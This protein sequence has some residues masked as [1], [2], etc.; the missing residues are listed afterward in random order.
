[1]PRNRTFARGFGGAVLAGLLAGVL[2]W[3]FGGGSRRLPAGAREGC[4]S[5]HVNVRGLAAA[6]APERVSCVACHLGDP[7]APEAAAAHRDMIRVPGHLATAPR[8]CGT[9]DCHPLLTAQIQTALMATGRGIVAVDRF[10]FGEAATPDGAGHLGRLGHSAADEHLRQLCEPCHLGFPKETPA[11]VHELSRGGGCVACHLRYSPAAGADLERMRTDRTAPATHPSLTLQVTDDHCFGCHSRSGRISLNYAGWSELRNGTNAP[12]PQTRRLADGRAV[13]AQPDDVHHAAG[14]ACIDCHTWRETMGDGQAHRH[15]EEQV[16]IGCADCH[17][18]T[19]ATVDA[20]ALA[21]VDRKLLALRGWPTN[22]HFLRIRKTG[23]ALLNARVTATGQAVLRSK[24]GDREWPLRPPAPACGRAI[25][26]HDRLSCKSCHAAWAPQCI[27]CHTQ[28]EARPDFPP[29]TLWA[30]RYAWMEYPGRFLAEPPVL[31]VRD[32]GNRIEPF[33]PGMILTLNTNAARPHAQGASGDRFLRLHA[34]V[35]PHT[36]AARGRDCRSCHANPVALGYGRGELTF[37][38]VG[39]GRGRWS[40]Q[41]AAAPHG[42]DGLPADAWIGFLREGI[43]PFATRADA[44]P[45]TVAEQQRILTV[46]ACLTCHPCPDPR[47]PA[48]YARFPESLARLSPSCLRP[49]WPP[50]GG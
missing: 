21:E 46:G 27:D 29:E 18:A 28:L 40:F 37:R 17:T 23:H 30:G 9:A 25:A 35:A 3:W 4:R 38:P 8:T 42:A 44:R 24:N 49:T 20:A 5:C 15:E 50:S 2:A 33:V 41:P 45:F 39:E 11:P 48:L 14:L 16:E 19:P 26:G 10:V 34:P 47:H 6:H 22:E 36:T 43:P 32:D 1:M 12:P 13:F 31:G 7:R